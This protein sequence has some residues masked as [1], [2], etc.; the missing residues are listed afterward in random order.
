MNFKIIH[1]SDLHGYFFPTDYLDRNKKNIGYFS[2]LNNIDKDE[3][4]IFTDGGDILQGSPFAYYVKENLNSKIIA[5]IMENVDFY[6]LGNHDFN[7]GYNY[8]KDYVQNMKGTLVCANVEDITG[9]IKINSYIIKEYNGIKFGITGIVTNWVNTWERKENL[10]NFKITDPFIAAKNVLEKMDC[11]IS[12]CIY[13]G[14]YEV[15]LDTMKKISDTDEN[16]GGKIASD[17]DFDILL[18][19]HQHMPLMSNING[20]FTIQP[21]SNGSAACVVNISKDNGLEISGD[22][23]YPTLGENC[24]EK[25]YEEVENKVQDFLDVPIATLE[26]DYFPESKIKM[27]LEGS[28]LADLINKIQM[29][30]S[31]A[32][33]SIT[34]FANEITGLKKNLTTRDVLNTYRFPNTPIVL[35][36]NGENLRKALEQN[37]TYI[38]YDGEFKI[39]KNFLEPK[40]EHY[41]FDFFYGIDFDLDFKSDKLI[42]NIYYKGKKIEDTDRFSIVMNNYRA[43]GAGGFYMYPHLK[44]LKTYDTEI[45]DILLEY[46]RSL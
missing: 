5:N 6:T 18:T 36:I 31:G 23:I 26:R 38:Q 7:Y 43:S 20:T 44:V 41:N 22:F 1:T 37:Y 9:E 42:G 10:L 17:L 46:F 15:D 14:G 33:I 32:D 19:G 39:S 34:S 8:L 11:D 13:H 28:P 35:E 4:T 12:I 25:K 16:I 45:S 27:A 3:F 24:L 40:E 2:L 30:F 29:E 21:P